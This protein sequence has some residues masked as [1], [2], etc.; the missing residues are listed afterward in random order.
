[1]HPELKTPCVEWF[2]NI[3]N[4][5]YGRICIK[6]QVQL[7][8]RVS[9]CHHNNVNIRDIEHLVIR[10]RCD[11]PLCINP[12]HLEPGTRTDNARDRVERGRGHRGERTGGSLLRED[13][14]RDI[15]KRAANGESQSSIAKLYGVTSSAIHYIV[16]RKNWAWLD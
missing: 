4:N 9:Y 15:R 12:E 11:N 1:M 14:V 3:N 16:S 7:A 8:H 2:G 13:E 5:G 10:H 6:R